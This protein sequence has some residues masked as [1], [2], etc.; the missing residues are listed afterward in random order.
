MSGDISSIKK[1]SFMNITMIDFCLL[2]PMSL[3]KCAQTLNTQ[4]KKF[5]YDIQSITKDNWKQNE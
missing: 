5:P 1:F 3:A 2:M 4:Q